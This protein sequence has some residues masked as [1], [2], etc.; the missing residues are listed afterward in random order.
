MGSLK[1]DYPN[2]PMIALTATANDRVKQ[3]VT[4]NLAME[5]PLMLQQS[6]NRA[7]LRYHVRK[8]TKH[9]LSDIADFVRTNHAGECGIIYC[10]S[11]KQCEDTAERLR[12]EHKVRAMHYHAVRPCSVFLWSP[13]SQSLRGRALTCLSHARWQGMDKN[14]RIR[15]QEQWQSGE[16]HLIC[17]TIACVHA[18]ALVEARPHGVGR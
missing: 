13:P 15:V 3:D 6:F 2:V 16:I 10:S 11:K 5:R 4:T 8:K 14:D 9:I 18:S 12:R 1:R 7:N 17:A